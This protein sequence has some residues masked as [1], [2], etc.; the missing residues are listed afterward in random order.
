MLLLH[1]VGSNAAGWWRVGEDLAEH[2]WTVV[3]PDLRGHGT[4]P[5]ADR[6]S[7]HDHAADVLALGGPWDAVLGHSMGG[8]VAVLASSRD[9]SLAA[10]LVLQDPAIVATPDREETIRGLVEVYERPLTPE[11]VAADNPRWHQRDCETKAEALLRTGP[12]LIR[13][14]VD[15]SWPWNVLA[16]TA[17]LSVPTTI[18][19]SDPEAGGIFAVALGEWLVGVNAKIDYRMLAGAAHS[20]HRCDDDYP[21]YF[22]EVR[23][24]LDG[25]PTLFPQNEEEA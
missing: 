23:S 6:Y 7:L 17:G 22:A 19:G 12:D 24:A 2:G 8:A 14:T 15:D 5:S 10:R 18:V 16:D 1:G 3:A 13:A 21:R 9:A 4:S 25:A 11:Q 20:A